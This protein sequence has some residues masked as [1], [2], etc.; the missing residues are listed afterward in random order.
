MLT[1]TEPV[2][3]HSPENTR[4]DEALGLEG[5]VFL[6]AMGWK[7]VCPSRSDCPAEPALRT[8]KIFFTRE[9][10]GRKSAFLP[11]K[12]PWFVFRAY[13]ALKPTEAPREG[14]ENSLAGTVRKKDT[15]EE[16]WKHKAVEITPQ[17]E[18][19]EKRY[20]QP[21]FTKA[22]SLRTIT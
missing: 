16:L 14:S 9:D 2:T 7:R 6:S 21:S 15:R 10:P 22:D 4:E 17:E 3:P 8:P 18:C 20:L 13:S 1:Q 11:H 12:V 19:G 5:G